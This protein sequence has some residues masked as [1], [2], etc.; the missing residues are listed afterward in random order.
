MFIPS[1]VLVRLFRNSKRRKTRLFQLDKLMSSF[2]RN[3]KDKINKNGKYSMEDL[4]K[5]LF[6]WWFKII[7]YI[8]SF[9]LIGSS[10][11]FLIAKG[12]TL[13][14]EKCLKWLTSLFVSL[15]AS[16]FLT[17]PFQVMALTFLFV[18]ILKSSNDKD[19]LG[20][21]NDDERSNFNPIAKWRLIKN[22]L[23]VLNLKNQF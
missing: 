15:L 9:L 20:N 22:N 12:I 4:K 17:Q 21:D 10:T 13:G 23:K 2:N 3:S 14:D 7:A 6:P 8:L 18:S 11:F 5:F 1:F 16:I 19:D